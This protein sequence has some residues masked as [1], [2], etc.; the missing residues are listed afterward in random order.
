MITLEKKIWA[1]RGAFHTRAGLEYD[2]IRRTA[3]PLPWSYSSYA[4]GGG[5]GLIWG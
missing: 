5:K 3:M 2:L 4:G 1:K